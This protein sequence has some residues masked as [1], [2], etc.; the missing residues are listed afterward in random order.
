LGGGGVE[1]VAFGDTSGD[2]GEEVKRCG[3]DGESVRVADGDVRVAVGVG[4]VDRPSG[5]C[6]LDTT[7]PADHGRR[8]GGELCG[9]AGEVLAVT[10][11]EQVGAELVDLIEQAGLGRGGQ[12][13]HGDDGGHPDGDA[14]GGHPGP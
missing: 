11:G 12:A 2:H 13:E 14:E 10:D 8:R 5:L 9:A 6:L 1:V 4:A 3:L 7:D